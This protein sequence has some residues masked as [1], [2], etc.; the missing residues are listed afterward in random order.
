LAAGRRAEAER[1]KQDLESFANEGGMISEQ[2][3]DSPD[4]PD[5]ELL[6]GRPSGSA[7]PLVWAHAEYI[8]LCRSLHD[9]KVFDLP[10][11]TYQ[12]YVVEHT[13]STYALWRFSHR[14]H[15]IPSKKVLRIEVQDPAMIHW[16]PDNW[17]TIA[18]VH[19]RESGF[20]LHIADLPTAT[21]T[22]A[23]VVRFT[24]FWR[25]AERWEGTDFAVKIENQE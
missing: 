7:M 1:L 9:G 22:L 21:L 19:T 12:R 8:K 24:F 18:D 14:C 17:N 23:N 2:I 15:A 10:S 4:V 5:R 25:D 20:G 6:F 16:S 11:Q 3:W 13:E